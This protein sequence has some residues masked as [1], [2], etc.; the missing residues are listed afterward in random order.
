M[1]DVCAI[2]ISWHAGHKNARKG[3]MLAQQLRQ[4]ERDGLV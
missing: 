3:K 1:Q 4:I 2:T